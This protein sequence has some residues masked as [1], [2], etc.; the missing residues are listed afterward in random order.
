MGG[1]YPPAETP[2]PPTLRDVER[3]FKIGPLTK[4]LGFWGGLVTPMSLTKKIKK[5]KFRGGHPNVP[6]KKNKK[7]KKKIFFW[8]VGGS[9]P[10]APEHF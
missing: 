7:I 3:I 4:K 1:S 9:F 6:D 5:K 8:G 2:P 10:N